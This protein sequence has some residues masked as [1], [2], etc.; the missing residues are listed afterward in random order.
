MVRSAG[1]TPR[2]FDRSRRVRKRSEFQRIQSSSKRVTTRHFILLV[3]VQEA[4]APAR[5]GLVVSRRI[6]GAVARNRVKRLCRECF[7]LSRALLP[8]GVDL[9]IIA[10]QGSES[11][12]LHEVQA[13]WSGAG[14]S[15]R[16]R[17]S[18]ALAERH[19]Q[20]HASAVT[21][22]PAR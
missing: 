19:E 5:L 1:Q 7:R 10:R 2:S 14:T 20:P 4:A 13:E 8:S 16:R 15:L 3:A 22:K 12:K 17:A 9:V 18:E 11:M 6:G 21:P